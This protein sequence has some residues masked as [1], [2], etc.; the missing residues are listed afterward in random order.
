VPTIF[1]Q[2]GYR[3]VVHTSRQHGPPHVHVIH[4][5]AVI[6][7]SIDGGVARFREG[8]AKRRKP[9]ER[10]IRRAEEIMSARL[11]DCIAA[12]NRYHGDP[13]S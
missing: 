5:D 7:I 3:V 8:S 1:E 4:G 6:V 2:D 11:G 10:E 12:W 9:P 13:A